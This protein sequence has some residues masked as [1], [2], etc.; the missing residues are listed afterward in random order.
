VSLRTLGRGDAGITKDRLIG[1][2]ATH[3]GPWHE[4]AMDVARMNQREFAFSGK[5]CAG[6]HQPG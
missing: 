3:V 1:S 6:D 4:A 2:V 5:D